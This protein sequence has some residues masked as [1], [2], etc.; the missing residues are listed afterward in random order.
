MLPD[1]LRMFYWRHDK[2]LFILNQILS[3]WCYRAVQSFRCSLH[4]K[5]RKVVAQVVCLLYHRFQCCGLSNHQSPPKSYIYLRGHYLISSIIATRVGWFI[6]FRIM[7]RTSAPFGIIQS[8]M[9]SP[10]RKVEKTGVPSIKKK[11]RLSNS[12]T[13]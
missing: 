12:I 2:L 3:M 9:I 8:V 11:N 1:L 6:I 4:L 10:S 13:L 5:D 7:S